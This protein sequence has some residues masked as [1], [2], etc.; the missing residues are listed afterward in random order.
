AEEAHST[1]A[2]RQTA[3]PLRNHWELHAAIWAASCGEPWLHP[4]WCQFVDRTRVRHRIGRSARHASAVCDRPDSERS[5][6]REHP[7]GTRGS[8]AAPTITMATTR[9]A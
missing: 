7:R 9:A 5:R 4:A 8:W 2:W 6:C 1:G 3:L